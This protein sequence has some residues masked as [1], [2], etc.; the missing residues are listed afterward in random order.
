VT[1]FV[2]I[3]RNVENTLET[4]LD[5]IFKLSPEVSIGRIIY[6]DSCSTDSS[7]SIAS[8]Y[9]GVQVI[10]ITASIPS[11][12]TGRSVG[13]AHTISENIVFVDG[14]MQ[15]L[16]NGILRA[17][18]L[19]DEYK[20][21]ITERHEVVLDVKGEIIKEIPKFY[22]ISDLSFVKK[23]GG[24]FVIK[25]D[26]Y[27][28]FGYNTLVVDEEESDLILRIYTKYRILPIAI[29]DRGYK[30]LNYRTK[31]DK[32]KLYLKAWSKT[33]Y[34]VSFIKAIRHNYLTGYL[35]IQRKY[36]LII[37]IY[38]LL[39]LQLIVGIK[40]AAVFYLAALLY[41]SLVSKGL[42]L[43]FLFFPYKLFFACIMSF[44]RNK[45]KQEFQ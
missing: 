31:Q 3:G 29:E 6:V 1:D 45:V 33:G 19:I 23:I 37:L 27:N 39:I 26:L 16:K 2:I 44:R 42:F 25:G 20:M 11:A 30:H 24:F 22:Q 9:G 34:L 10:S 35:V 12:A 40:V 4:C 14:D 13:G 17:L 18:S 41:Y 32:M 28:E 38:T 7:L 21:L 8:N 36:S 5:S 43:T 15:L